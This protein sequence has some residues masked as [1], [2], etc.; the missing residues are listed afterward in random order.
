[1][2]QNK[3]R[4]V[5]SVNLFLSRGDVVPTAR[6]VCLIFQLQLSRVPE[7]GVPIYGRSGVFDPVDLSKIWTHGPLLGPNCSGDW[8]QLPS[9]R[10]SR[11]CAITVFAIIG[12]SAT[13]LWYVL[14]VG[15]KYIILHSISL[16]AIHVFDPLLFAGH[17]YYRPPET[18][19][20]WI[21]ETVNC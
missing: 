14:T 10:S 8:R 5:K 11:T 2:I 18:I 13:W 15:I 6:Q 20:R 3:L 9:N 17:P 19:P 7:G 21:I 1:M 4:F 12:S 16:S